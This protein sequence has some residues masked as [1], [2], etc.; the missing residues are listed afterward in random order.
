MEL[1]LD[2]VY[3]NTSPYPLYFTVLTIQRMKYCNFELRNRLLN[4]VAN[5]KPN[6]SCVNFWREPDEQEHLEDVLSWIKS[7]RYAYGFNSAMG[8][9]NIMFR[10]FPLDES[11]WYQIEHQQKYWHTTRESRRRFW[12]DDNDFEGI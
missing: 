8:D 9:K 4:Q 7:E 11:C 5:T 10:G 2:K 12:G 1:K 3:S 6:Y